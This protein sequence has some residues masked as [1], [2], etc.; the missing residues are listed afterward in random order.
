MKNTNDL[1]E[2]KRKRYKGIVYLATNI[3]NDKKYVGITT[4]EFTKRINEHKYDSLHREKGNKTYFHKAIYKYGFDNFKF[5]IIKEIEGENQ[6][7]LS[8]ELC[9]LERYYINYYSTFNKNKGY[10]LTLGG[11]GIYGFTLS[12]EQK[13]IVS[14][15]HKGKH[16]SEEHKK[17][18][19][20]FM[21]SDKN[22]RKGV[23]MSEETKKKI[24]NSHIGLLKGS[25]NPMYGKKREDVSK[26]NVESGYTILQIDPNTNNVIKVWNSLREVSRETGWN[27]SCISDCCNNKTKISHGYVWKYAN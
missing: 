23:P 5:E 18:I 1:N 22:P 16:L 17:I 6:D 14:K 13:D 2:K 25:K 10:N 26:R 4:R 11:D 8:E 15:T 12:Q 19:S 21:K 20:N 24:S 3:V 27:R 9:E 7:L